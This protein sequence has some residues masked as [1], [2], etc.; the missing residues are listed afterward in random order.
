MYFSLLQY[1]EM[2][3]EKQWPG[4]CRTDLQ[5]KNVTVVIKKKMKWTK[6]RREKEKNKGNE[7]K[8]QTKNENFSSLQEILMIMEKWKNGFVD[9]WK[10]GYV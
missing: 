9:L 3:Y 4:N 10:Y 6:K 8:N 7:L 1:L 2:C 5:L